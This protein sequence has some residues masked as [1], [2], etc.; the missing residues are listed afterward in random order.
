MSPNLAFA[1]ALA[2]CLA[3]ALVSLLLSRWKTVAGWAAFAAVLSSSALVIQSAVSVLGHG[4][5]PGL[6][7]FTLPSLGRAREGQAALQRLIARNAGDSA[8]QVAEVFAWQRDPDRAFEWLERAYAYRDT[9]LGFTGGDPLLR[10]L[11]QDARWKPFLR[12]L[13]LPAE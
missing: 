2:I 12:R 10:P 8:Y 3:G 9:G 4:A 13:N 11:H 7:L 1:Y 5:A 6:I